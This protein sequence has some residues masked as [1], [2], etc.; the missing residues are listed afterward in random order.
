MQRH[1][2]HWRRTR[3][4]RM[5]TSGHPPRSTSPHPWHACGDVH[6]S[7]TRKPMEIASSAQSMGLRKSCIG[8]T[9]RV[10]R[11]A[12][13][14]SIPLSYAIPPEQSGGHWLGQLRR[15]DRIHRKS[16]GSLIF[17][18]AQW[19]R[20]VCRTGAA[21]IFIAA[22][23]NRATV[24]LFT[25]PPCLRSESIRLHPACPSR[26]LH[27]SIAAAPTACRTASTPTQQPAPRVLHRF[28]LQSP[29]PRPVPP[30]GS[31]SAGPAAA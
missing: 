3:V 24:P 27:P 19:T 31:G 9:K 5:L 13:Y 28:R 16:D 30:T 20:R 2:S 26:H 21:A 10:F 4:Q 29:P 6:M 22:N 1:P 11:N 23:L 18:P 14:A 15:S 7:E 8:S 17:Y 25:A 12:L